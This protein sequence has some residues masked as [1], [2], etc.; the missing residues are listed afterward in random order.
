MV[1]EKPGLFDHHVLLR[2]RIRHVVHDKRRRGPRSK[3]GWG[4][5]EQQNFVCG[6]FE[7]RVKSRVGIWACSPGTPGLGS[8][9]RIRT[10]GFSP[11]VFLRS[12][13]EMRENPLKLRPK[14]GKTDGAN[15]SVASLDICGSAMSPS[16]NTSSR[17]FG[18]VASPCGRTTPREQDASP[19]PGFLASSPAQSL[20]ESRKKP[21]SL[22]PKKSPT[23]TVPTRR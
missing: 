1:L 15:P 8:T 11:R 4:L 6:V 13:P 3:I 23:P 17:L 2:A 7:R 21:P 9:T 14:S 16:G 12:L 22:H 20:A 5:P 18:P 19:N 10:C